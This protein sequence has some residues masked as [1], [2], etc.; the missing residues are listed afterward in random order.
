MPVTAGRAP[1]G[2]T[3]A[4][5]V[6]MRIIASLVLLLMCLLAMWSSSHSDASAISD[7][8]SLTLMGESG[9]GSQTVLDEPAGDVVTS[10]TQALPAA[11][12]ALCLV[13]V[14]VGGML[15]ERRFR[16]TR[17]QLNAICS[18]RRDQPRPVRT[19]RPHPTTLS[20][21]ELSLSQT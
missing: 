11:A 19:V 2:S 18:H 13:G 6:R 17:S 10:L 12:V 21:T 7:V 3:T 20:L 9:Q 15:L 14:C 16:L 1:L 4:S 8:P 5:V